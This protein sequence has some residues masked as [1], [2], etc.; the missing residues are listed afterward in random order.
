MEKNR[1]MKAAKAT[2]DKIKKK[3]KIKKIEPSAYA[4]KNLLNKGDVKA[5]KSSPPKKKKGGY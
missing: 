3:K 1:Y 4:K 2:M 5:K